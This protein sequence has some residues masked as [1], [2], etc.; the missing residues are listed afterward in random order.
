[1]HSVKEATPPRTDPSFLARR[2]RILW[3]GE[4]FSAVM[5]P[6]LMLWF[7]A[8]D[9]AWSEWL[10]RGYAVAIVSWILLQGVAWWRWK[11]RLL[12]EGRR[13]MPPQVL[14]VYRRLRSLNWLLIALFPLVP[15]LTW[16]LTGRV[17]PVADIVLGL[18]FLGGAV[19]EQINYYYVQLMYD[20]PY[21]WA[22]LR[23]HRRLR[24]GS[25]AKALDS[26]TTL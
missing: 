3:A 19:L 10:S 12:R 2:Y 8:R 15:L 9:G 4:L 13:T 16:A 18:L 26:A 14:A 24:R 5:F 23:R 17:P 6:V 1:M 20:N 21:D 22:Y 25:I 7:A 11:L